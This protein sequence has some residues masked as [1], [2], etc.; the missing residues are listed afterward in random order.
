M[1]HTIQ[2]GR[3]YLIPLFPGHFT[4]G[5]ITSNTG[6]I[7]QNINIATGKFGNLLDTCGTRFAV[8]HIAVRHQN[9]VAIGLLLLL[10]GF[11]LVMITT[12]IVTSDDLNAIVCQSTTNSRANTTCT[13]SNQCN[14]LCHKYSPCCAL[15][16]INKL[17]PHFYVTPRRI[18]YSW[19]CCTFTR[20]W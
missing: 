20:L 19:V 17:N 2:V 7:D 5:A 10:P 4:E 1:K 15:K 16:N 12:G 8:R 18:F 14:G 6:I 13:T 11:R 3:Q 9:I